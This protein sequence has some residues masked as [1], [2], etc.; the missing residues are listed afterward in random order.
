MTMSENTR[1]AL[2]TGSNRG[3]GRE[4]VRQLAAKGMT[5]ILAAR[6][7]DK[8]KQAAREL[9]D[10]GLS[11]VGRQLDVTD[12]DS[13]ARLARSVAEEFGRLDVLVNNAG[14][15][16]DREEKGTTVNLDAVRRT[17]ETNVLGAWRVA[18]AF[19][20]LL[21]RSGRGRVVNI[22]SQLGQLKD[23]GDGYPGYRVSKAALNA[24]T[25][26]FA[27]ALRG[28]GV[29]VNSA[30][31]GWVK[32]DMGGPDAPG[33]VEQG[34]DTPVWLATLPDNGPTG[35]FFQNRRPIPW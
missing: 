20:P 18:Q 3:I 5:A 27:D 35:G 29:L 30:C 12:A 9:A 10:Q 34:A 28:S 15:L 11:V 14:I 26:I 1:I 25:R 33:S 24:L 13:V 7:A 17:L 16:L 32:T 4:I 22:S 21:T 31:P 23:M 2:V 6:D 8:A 19:A